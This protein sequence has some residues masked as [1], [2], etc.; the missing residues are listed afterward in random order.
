MKR[1]AAFN[2]ELVV[3]F[4][5]NAFSA[6]VIRYAGTDVL[7]HESE[8]SPRTHAQR[9]KRRQECRAGQWRDDAVFDDFRS[10]SALDHVFKCESA[11][12]LTSAK[13]RN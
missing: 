10:L 7:G 1:Y 11:R 3:V 2:G 13:S 8:C 6:N 4:Q 5:L 12:R 9:A